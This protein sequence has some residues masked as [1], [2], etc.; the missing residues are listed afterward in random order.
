MFNPIQWFKAMFAGKPTIAEPVNL[1]AAWRTHVCD[2]YVPLQLQA[3]AV[4][5]PFNAACEWQ[6]ENMHNGL[7]LDK[8]SLQ[9]EFTRLIKAMVVFNQYVKEEFFK[10]YVSAQGAEWKALI[11]ELG[12]ATEY[13][14]IAKLIL[15][16]A[17]ETT[18]LAC[19]QQASDV[20]N[21]NELYETYATGQNAIAK[22]LAKPIQQSANMG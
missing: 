20:I 4:C 18:I 7:P 11:A 3:I 21:A 13:L 5:A 12:A 10:W 2:W 9:Q 16:E 17:I 22:L 19:Q 15:E 8:T 14:A 6:R 1:I